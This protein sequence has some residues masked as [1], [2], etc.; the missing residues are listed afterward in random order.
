VD[1]PKVV[2]P[3]RFV[4]ELVRAGVEFIVVGG[5]A[6]LLHGAPITTQDLDVVHRRTQDNVARL[7]AL[8]LQLDA[9][10]R[11]DLANRRLRPTAEMLAGHGQIN[12][13]TTLGPFDPLCELEVGQGYE[14]LLPHTEVLSEGD[15]SFRVIDLP[16]LIEVKMKT[17]RAKDRAVVPILM[18][19][20]KERGLWQFMHQSGGTLPPDSI[21]EP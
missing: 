20:L 12:L 10:M 21:E 11:Y 2:D 14:E 15:T 7:L 4:T 13:S 18:A 3:E 5:A 17:G 1:H 6:G 19:V 16:T 9:F 8:L